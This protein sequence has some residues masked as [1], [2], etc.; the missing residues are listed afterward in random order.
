MYIAPLEDITPRFQ[1]RSFFQGHLHMATLVV[2]ES[3]FSVHFLVKT[4]VS[5]KQLKFELQETFLFNPS[6]GWG[7]DK[8]GN[9]K[10]DIKDGDKFHAAPVLVKAFPLGSKE[11]QSVTLA[12]DF[13]T[14]ISFFKENPT[15]AIGIFNK[16]PEF[17]YTITN[18]SKEFVLINVIAADSDG[19]ETIFA[20]DSQFLCNNKPVCKTSYKTT[21]QN[22]PNYVTLRAYDTK[23]GCIE[24]NIKYIRKAG[25]V[26]IISENDS[27][28]QEQDRLK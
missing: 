27:E 6:A 1:E 20:D 13:V 7:Y 16:K 19:L 3:F 11:R 23:G 2:K 9:G 8:N 24:K 17:E 26:Q 10:F 28:Y 18:L 25:S 5:E 21:A 12:D 15:L 22:G 14:V 4:N